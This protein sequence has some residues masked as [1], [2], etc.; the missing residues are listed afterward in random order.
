MILVWLLAFLSL[1]ILGSL[2]AFVYLHSAESRPVSRELREANDRLLEMREEHKRS[3][4]S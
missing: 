2:V 4:R 1:C 3:K